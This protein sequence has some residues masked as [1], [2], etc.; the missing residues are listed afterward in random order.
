MAL[1]L[2]TS[3]KM[4]HFCGFE[5]MVK[6]IVEVGKSAIQKSR[7][8]CLEHSLVVPLS[9]FVSFINERFSI[10]FIY[11]YSLLLVLKCKPSWILVGMFMNAGKQCN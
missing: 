6:E 1:I 7:E 11:G 5:V 8:N 10:L 4:E 9:K 3:C 2:E